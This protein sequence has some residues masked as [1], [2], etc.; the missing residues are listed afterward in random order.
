MSEYQNCPRCGSAKVS[1][2]KRWTPDDG[3]PRAGY[4]TLVGCSECDLNTVPAKW[5]TI[6][7][8]STLMRA[9]NAE[10][11]LAFLKDKA[12]NLRDLKDCAEA[13][14]D[15]ARALIIHFCIAANTSNTADLIAATFEMNQAQR[16]WK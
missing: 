6:R 1:E 16:E 13:E 14:R 7:K 4:V 10:A 9:E 5:N 8:S 2:F 15:A 3:D 11:E 12:I